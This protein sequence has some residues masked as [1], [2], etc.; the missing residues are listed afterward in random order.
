MDSI[1]NFGN[2]LFNWLSLILGFLI[3]WWMNTQRV[4]Y[5]G[6]DSNIVKKEID[7]RPEGCFRYYVDP[8]IC[9]I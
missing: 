7:C 6:P 8:I 5:H 9:P 3:I 2:N 1:S 4:I